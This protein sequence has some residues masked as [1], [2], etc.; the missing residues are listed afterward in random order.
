[1]F[2][3]RAFGRVI[4]SELELPEFERIP[5][6]DCLTRDLRIVLR[7]L[8]PVPVEE[9]STQFFRVRDDEIDFEVEGIVRIRIPGTDRI[10]V[11]VLDPA[12]ERDARLYVTGSAFG[13]WTFL[14]GRFP[15]HCGLVTR[16]GMG[17]ALTGPS[18][19]GKSTLTTALVR[20]NFGFMSDDMVV[21]DQPEG[22][23]TR[24]IPS[25]ARIKLWQEAADHFSIDT[26]GFNRLHQEMDKYHV[27]FS[28][29]KIVEEATLGA[30]FCLRFDDG[31][32]RARCRKLSHLEALKELRANIYRPSLIP[33]LDMERDAF[34]LI[35]NILQKVPV[36]E[37][38]RPRSFECFDQTIEAIEQEV[39][40]LC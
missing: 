38:T 6:S 12:K 8:Q 17:F 2:L 40:A 11:D 3:Y 35:A 25:F 20:R 7:P 1:M 21:F 36:F 37:I 19:V 18:G 24:I 39:E 30:V 28:Q 22:G 32:E 4:E 13:A 15:F 33:A 27:P 5:E 31:G 10:G 16:N 29:E 14:T 23:D 9:W 34:Q 26:S